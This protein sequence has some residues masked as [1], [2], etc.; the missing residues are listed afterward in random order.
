MFNTTMLPGDEIRAVLDEN[1]VTY[2]VRIE[3]NWWGGILI[4]LVPIA[5]IS[6]FW[7][8]ICRR[9]NPGQQAMNIGK[10]KTALY[11]KQSENKA[12][13]QDAAELKEAKA[14]V[15]QQ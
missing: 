2:D 13:L 8:F 9:M 11:D 12:S 7:V 3:E 10:N 6:A 4:W 5:L 14:D 15:K 1:S